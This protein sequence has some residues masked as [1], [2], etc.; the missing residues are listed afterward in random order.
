MKLKLGPAGPVNTHF[1]WL[2]PIYDHLAPPAG[3]E[4]LRMLLRPAPDALLLDAGGGTGRISFPL[5]SFFREVVVVDLSRAML[6]QSRRKPGLSAIQADAGRLPFADAAFDRILTVDSLHHFAG[7]QEVVCEL[8]RVLK[9][10]GLLV[11]EE[12]NLNRLPV[13][14]LALFE[15]IILM[16]SHFSPPGRIE[17]M[18]AACGATPVIRAGERFTVWIVCEKPS[19]EIH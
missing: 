7:Q 19:S 9:P 11:I 14:L 18:V 5:L 2:A 3:I 16:G 8:M 4:R 13:K 12:F 15:K 6:K 17:E 10:G 1:D